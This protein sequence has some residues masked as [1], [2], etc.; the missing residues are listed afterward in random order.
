MRVLRSVSVIA[1]AS[2]IAAGLWALAMPPLWTAFCIRSLPGLFWPL[3]TAEALI[4]V[5]YVVAIPLWIYLLM[6][7]W[8]PLFLA[9]VAW[10]FIAFIFNCGVGHFFDIHILSAARPAYGMYLVQRWS[11]AVVT[12]TCAVVGLVSVART[13]A[14]LSATG[15]A[16]LEYVVSVNAVQR[17][18]REQ[19]ETLRRIGAMLA[20]GKPAS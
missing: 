8:R 16:L 6:P 17:H 14:L 5:S 12:V 9:G 2:T 3:V 10:L 7:V 13:R 11:T 18:T 1:M 4:G 19:L 20:K 15:D